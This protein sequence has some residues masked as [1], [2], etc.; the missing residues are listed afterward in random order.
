[1]LI[2]RNMGM[3]GRRRVARRKQAGFTLVEL[4]AVVTI[5]GVLAVIGVAL[6]RKHI[7]TSRAV[8]A[9]TMVQSI[10]A[11]QERWFAETRTYFD[12]STTMVSYYPMATPG[13]NKYAW[14]QPGG[15]DFANWRMLNP[16]VSG[17]VQFG[18]TTRAGAPGAT[19]PALNITN[20]PVWGPAQEP[21]YVIQATGDTNGDGVFAM[22]A[23]SSFSLDFYAEKSG[24]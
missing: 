9:S 13:E 18:Y 20:P 21:W 22:F 6:V 7:L 16:S 24:E 23:A 17:P 12:V 15:N 19:P 10:R 5:V 3:S 4:M 1:M 8:E 11:A 14:D 2:D